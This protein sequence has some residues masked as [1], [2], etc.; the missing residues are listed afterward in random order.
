M[1]DTGGTLER[2]DIEG[3]NLD[4]T[5]A[6]VP[7]GDMNG[8]IDRFNADEAALENCADLANEPKDRAAR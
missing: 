8:Q 7:L 2:S 5:D 3:T 6:V 4:N 1:P